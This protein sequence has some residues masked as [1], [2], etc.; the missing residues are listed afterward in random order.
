MLQG[1]TL[2][3]LV[4]WGRC[5]IWTPR[6]ALYLVTYGYALLGTNTMRGGRVL[7]AF[8]CITSSMTDRQ[9]QKTGEYH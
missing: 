5:G 4:I 6:P 3:G 1:K 2:T 9:P 8:Q 7:V